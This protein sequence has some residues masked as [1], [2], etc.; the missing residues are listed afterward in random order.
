MPGDIQCL[1]PAKNDG[2]YKN[3]NNDK[4]ADNPEV[5][6]ID[7]PGRIMDDRTVETVQCE[8]VV[9]IPV[10]PTGG[11]LESFTRT[12]SLVKENT[13]C[14]IVI[15]VNGTNRFTASVSFM[16]WLQKYRQKETIDT[17]LT[18]PQSEAIVQAENYSCSINDINRHS[19]AA[20][21]VNMMCDKI[22]ELAGLPVEKR[23]A[24]KSK[25]LI[26]K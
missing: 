3:R 13:N 11:N 25:K 16:E 14:P 5:A 19:T 4:K 7:T 23:E 12:V 26:A 15:A 20:Q 24:K 17:V 6:V 22:S 21:A 9:V 8:D 10:R 2:Q 1:S 18:I